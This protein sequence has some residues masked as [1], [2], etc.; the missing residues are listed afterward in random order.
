[1]TYMMTERSRAAAWKNSTSALPDAARTPAAYVAKSGASS[2]PAYDWCLPR[3]FAALSLLPDIREHAIALFATMGIPWHAGVDGGPSNHLLSSQVQCVNALTAMVT[4]P[5]RITRAFGDLLGVR[6][7]LPIEPGRFLTFE[8]IGPT[9]YFGEC[10]GRDRV[11]GA[12]CTSVDAAFLHRGADGVVEL[13]LL[14]WKY[15]ESYRLRPQEPAK[16]AVRR[17]RYAAAVDDPTGPVRGERLAFEHLLD[18][19]FYQLVRQQLLAAALEQDGAEGAQRVRVVHVLPAGNH[20][21]QQSLARPEHRAL[22]NTVGEVWQRLLRHPDRFVAVDSA[23][24]LDPQITSREY[25]LR[26]GDGVV[27]DEASVLREFGE[28]GE[29][30]ED[31][32]DFEGYVVQRNTGIEL[33][34]NGIGV[35]LEYPFLVSEL[36]NLAAE[37]EQEHA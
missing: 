35:E 33:I 36:Y 17:G 12:H 5:A 22:G 21:Y 11:R 29:H 3:E 14:E 18:E 8:Y 26:Y 9:D 25:A 7:V 27:H 13:V 30:L 37:L 1:M 31:V 10:P 6:E 15:T 16:D 2:G 34:M 19:P 32:L 28:Q 4:D 23:V 20:A 24:F